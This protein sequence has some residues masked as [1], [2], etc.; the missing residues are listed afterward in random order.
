MP[1]ATDTLTP[2]SEPLLSG[3]DALA[4][5]GII[6]DAAPA[7]G[8][9]VIDPDAELISLCS[10]AHAVYLAAAERMVELPAAGLAGLGAKARVLKAYLPGSD[11]AMDPLVLSLVTD[12]VRLAGGAA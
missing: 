2:P 4:A 8:R 11:G 9:P 1:R 10:T 3:K 6:A 7:G 5:I 12:C